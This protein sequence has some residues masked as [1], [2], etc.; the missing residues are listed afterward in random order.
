MNFSH[1]CLQYFYFRERTALTPAHN[2]FYM[3]RTVNTS[4]MAGKLEDGGGKKVTQNIH[5][6]SRSK[7]LTAPYYYDEYC[8]HHCHGC[9]HRIYEMP[10]RTD[11]VPGISTLIEDQNTVSSDCTKAALIYSGLLSRRKNIYNDF[12]LQLL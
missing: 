11:R 2:F 7:L 3:N 8:F 10:A 5:S 4:L 1:A 9:L 6:L 12:L